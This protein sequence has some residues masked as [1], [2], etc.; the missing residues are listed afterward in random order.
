MSTPDRVPINANA[1][2]LEEVRLA[3]AVIDKNFVMLFAE[4]EKL[5][6]ASGARP[7]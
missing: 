7:T 1:C 6:P 5:K 4:L 2:N 3:L